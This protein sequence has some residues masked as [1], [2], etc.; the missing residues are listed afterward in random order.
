MSD[1]Q[2]QN[3]SSLKEESRLNKESWNI[4]FIKVKQKT[5]GKSSQLHDFHVQEIEQDTNI[6]TWCIEHDKNRMVCRHKF[7][8]S[9]VS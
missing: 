6:L 8:K 5:K 7:L 9:I 4:P 2:L 3:N 1:S